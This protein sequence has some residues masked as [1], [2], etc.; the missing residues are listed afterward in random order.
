MED[1]Q[2]G[3]RPDNDYWPD[4]QDREWNML[5]ARCEAQGYV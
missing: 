4:P 1:I 2:F 5:V 3:P